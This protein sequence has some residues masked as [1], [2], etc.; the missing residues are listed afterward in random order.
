MKSGKLKVS[1]TQT[2]FTVVDKS[3]AK[4]PGPKT[5]SKG[6]VFE[7][8]PLKTSSG[9][10]NNTSRN[11]NR[12]YFNVMGDFLGDNIA[13]SLNKGASSD[14]FLVEEELQ[15]LDPSQPTIEVDTS[16]APNVETAAIIQE[17]EEQPLAPIDNNAKIVPLY[18]PKLESTYTLNELKQVA[19]QNKI[20]IKKITAKRDIYNILLTE[21][22]V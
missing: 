10:S 17:E 16:V 14:N 7:V 22:L 4:K 13:G 20:N 18:E 19:K 1:K 3:L 21:E 12:D 2:G 11:M 8:S 6:R 5:N 9:L 15:G